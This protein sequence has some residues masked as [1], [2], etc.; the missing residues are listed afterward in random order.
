MPLIRYDTG[1]IGILKKYQ[2]KGREFMVF[3]RIEGRK[4]DSIYTTSGELL[5]S[6]IFPN[7][8]RKYKNIKQFQFVQYA[9]DRYK[10]ILNT[11]SHFTKE[12]DLIAE[13]K[14]LLGEKSSLEIEYVK[15][16]PLL[17]SGK[18]KKVINTYSSI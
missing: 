12:A 10:F 4:M 11:N 8:L 5:S 15:A 1:D 7:K 17:S 6:F 16:I 2:H 9:P 13:F 14:P 18:R 3:S